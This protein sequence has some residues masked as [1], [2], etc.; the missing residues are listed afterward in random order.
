MDT[1]DVTETDIPG[2]L[3]VVAR[4][5]GPWGNRGEW[6]AYPRGPIKFFQNNGLPLTRTVTTAFVTQRSGQFKAMPHVAIHL[7]VVVCRWSDGTHG[8]TEHLGAHH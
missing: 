1:F 6:T 2:G 3:F 5:G 8:L 7:P 4:R